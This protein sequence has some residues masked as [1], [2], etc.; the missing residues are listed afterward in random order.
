MRLRD[1]LAE[2]AKAKGRE[3]LERFLS[4]GP[5]KKATCDCGQMALVTEEEGRQTE[6]TELLTPAL[7]GRPSFGLF[8]QPAVP[9]NPHPAQR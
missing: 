4:A 2:G 5:G 1:V 8:F 6:R 3:E 7:V 9:Q